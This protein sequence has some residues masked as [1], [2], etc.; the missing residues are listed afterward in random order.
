MGVN[1][2]VREYFRICAKIFFTA[3]FT[4]GSRQA[5]INNCQSIG[6]YSFSRVKA[7]ASATSSAPALHN[8][9]DLIPFVNGQPQAKNYVKN[10]I[11][12]HKEKQRNMNGK[13]YFQ[14]VV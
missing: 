12:S 7:P 8:D 2:N 4:S 3:H 6:S 9:K 1:I 11:E 10:I 5:A 13:N 14:V